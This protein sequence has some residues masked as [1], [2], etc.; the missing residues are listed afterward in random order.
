MAPTRSLTSGNAATGGG[1]YSHL[2]RFSVATVVVIACPTCG[3]TNLARPSCVACAGSGLRRA[4]L[5]LTVANLDT[6]AVA[7]ERL[8]PGSLVSK[9]S[10][11]RSQNG[12]WI[13]DLSEI[14]QRLGTSVAAKSIFDVAS[15]DHLFNSGD[16]PTLALPDTWRGDLAPELREAIEARVLV[17]QSPR[18][19]RLF[20]GRSRAMPPTDPAARLQHLCDLAD[21]LRV[22]LVIEARP[23]P[24]ATALSWDIRFDLPST[25]VPATP[26]GDH[27][28]LRS[29]L[30]DT[31]PIIALRDISNRP[32][33]SHPRELAAIPQS[34]ADLETITQWIN[35]DI[36]QNFGYAQLVWRDRRWHRAYPRKQAGHDGAEQDRSTQRE[37][38]PQEVM[39]TIT[40]LDTRADHLVLRADS[41]RLARPSQQPTA[42]GCGSNDG[43][44]API[45]VVT[46]PEEF[47]LARHSARYGVTATDLIDLHTGR[48][49][50]V[51]LRYGLMSVSGS[52]TSAEADLATSPAADPVIDFLT[53]ITRGRSENRLFIGALTSEIPP[54]ERL[55]RLAVNLEL[56]IDL[57]IEICQDP[58]DIWATVHREW[59]SVDLRAEDCPEPLTI[60]PWQ[61]S[62]RSALQDRLTYLDQVAAQAVPRDPNHPLPAPDSTIAPAPAYVER[63]LAALLR[64]L[65][66]Q[67]PDH[68]VI[69]R[70]DRR[71]WRVYRGPA[72]G[73]IAQ[74]LSFAPTLR[75]A[76]PSWPMSTLG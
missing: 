5:V 7:S 37:G 53:Q 34:L 63:D 39:V 17:E 68:P 57:T 12:E 41:A 44:A 69:C 54:L 11:K 36:N 76:A 62:L 72:P 55:V 26:Y 28:D 46:L 22:D 35:E 30:V 23:R 8:V 50:D 42:N 21:L 73:A 14:V 52:P 15:P 75:A 19:W 1:T 40:D 16:G 61:P 6:G 32:G 29:A 70:R 9:C 67:Y 64:Q 4:Q 25:G 66:A 31:D 43:C 71:G 10:P 2:R 49:A 27:P 74:L 45:R 48:V 51:R 13:A 18:P 3:N 24:D 20:L 33:N 38:Q 58:S 59:W 65:G 47:R 56:T 60:E